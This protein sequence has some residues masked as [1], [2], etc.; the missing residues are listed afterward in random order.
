MSL[1]NRS[2]LN[3]TISLT[4]KNIVTFVNSLPFWKMEFLKK[5]LFLFICHLPFT[6]CHSLAL[7]QEVTE[8]RASGTLTNY[9][10]D[11]PDLVANYKKSFVEE[12]Q[13]E[14]FGARQVTFLFFFYFFFW[15]APFGYL[16]FC[17]FSL[18]CM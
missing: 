17:S 5:L 1:L 16:Y 13:L 6:I 7:A 9:I 12:I 10:F 3:Q 2:K 11:L 15:C 8:D 18:V 4:E 14:A